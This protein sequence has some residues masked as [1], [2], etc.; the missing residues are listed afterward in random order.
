VSRSG[1]VDQ[2]RRERLIKLAS[3]AAFLAIVVVAVLIVL[4]E[5][6]TDGG[7]SDLEGIGQVKR[8]LR[9]IPQQGLVLGDPAAPVTLVEFGDLQCPACKAYAEDVVPEVIEARVRNGR[10]RIEFRNYTILGEDS[11]AAGAAAVAAGEQGRGWQFVELFYRN[12]GFE[13]SGYVTEDFLRSVALG[14]GVPAMARWNRDRGSR[15][16]LDRVAQTSAEAQRLG[17]GGTPSFAVE[18]PRS[19]GLEPLDGAAT[20][21]DLEAA[22][23][24]AG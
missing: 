5:S 2:P 19:D 6:Q 7:D 8:D 17:I 11:V 3:A 15:R 21:G 4:S 16:I 20:A 12:Q 23:D 13:G 1:A 9:G 18:G 14:A 10:A 24:D 22:I